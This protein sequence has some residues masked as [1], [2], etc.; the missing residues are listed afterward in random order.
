MSN[1]QLTVAASF[2]ALID[3]FFDNALC[4]GVPSTTPQPGESIEAVILDFCYYSASTGVGTSKLAEISVYNATTDVVTR[5]SHLTKDCSGPD[6]SGGIDTFVLASQPCL[7]LGGGRFSKKILT[8]VSSGEFAGLADWSVNSFSGATPST[9]FPEISDLGLPSAGSSSSGHY[10]AGSCFEVL[11]PLFNSISV[12]SSSGAFADVATHQTSDCTGAGTPL[13]DCI[14][15]PDFNRTFFAGDLSE[16]T[17]FPTS[18]PTF[19]P[20]PIPTTLTPTKSPESSATSLQG[21]FPTIGLILAI[22]VT[23]W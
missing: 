3:A 6:T 8:T 4:T 19:R 18:S 9:C 21:V 22:T 10:L 13:V 5:S 17:P 15:V 7:D 16:L 23:M 14:F 20:T 2:P 1:W 12:S 11:T